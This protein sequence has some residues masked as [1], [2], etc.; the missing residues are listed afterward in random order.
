MINIY[1]TSVRYT[2]LS[3]LF[4]F[5]TSSCSNNSDDT[6][7][8]IIERNK[9]IVL[10]TNQPST[11]YVGSDDKIRGPEYSLTQEYAGYLQV[12]TEY[13]VLDSISD[14]L[15]A[16]KAGEGDIAAA[17]LT[18]TEKRK[19][20]FSFGPSYLNVSEYLVCHRSTESPK[21]VDDLKNYDI[22]IAKDSS[23][24]ENIKVHYT[25]TDITVSPDLTSSSILQSVAKKD[26]ECTIIDSNIFDI[27]RRFYPTI[28]HKYTLSSEANLAWATRHNNKHLNKS[29]Q[30]WFMKFSQSEK[31][32]K[33]YDTYYGHIDEFDYVDIQKFRRRIKSRLPKYI[34]TFQSAAKKYDIS[35]ALLMAQSYQESHWDPRAKSFT[36]VRGM[37]MLTQP[38]A[39][40]LGVKSRLNASENII[41]GARFFKKIKHMFDEEV[42]DPD[43]TWMALAAYNVGRGHFRDAQELA[44]KLGKSPYSWADMKTVLPLLSE[45]KYYKDLRYGYARGNEPVQYVQRI[46]EYENI[47]LKELAKN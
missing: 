4:L 45:K 27:N 31:F 22:V 35:P 26:I 19:K 41:A 2:L 36:G 24:Y 13:V 28:S 37:M 39:K 15:N 7:K 23:Y 47:L 14:V 17:G 6:L 20:H 10:T 18:I 38:V 40:S 32:A 44:K 30:R 33:H 29:L 3:L 5:V 21:S 1:S 11:Y 42:E 43:R 34:S 8:R 9:L 16:L 12:D 25:D 46:R